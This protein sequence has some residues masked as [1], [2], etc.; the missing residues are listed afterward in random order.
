MPTKTVYTFPNVYASQ[1]VKNETKRFSKHECDNVIAVCSKYIQ[2]S[3]DC[4]S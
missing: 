2:I 3:A 1:R 4:K